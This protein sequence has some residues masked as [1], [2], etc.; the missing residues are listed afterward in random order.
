MEKNPKVTAIE[1]INQFEN[2][3]MLQDYGGM[4]IGLAKECAIIA[5][6]NIIKSNAIWHEDSIPYKFWTQVAKEIINYEW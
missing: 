4:D 5:V 6:D 3:P 2:V 1:L